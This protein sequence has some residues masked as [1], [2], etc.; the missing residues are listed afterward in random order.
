M[1]QG[2]QNSFDGRGV[3]MV[4][5]LTKFKWLPL[6]LQILLR[7]TI[8]FN[9]WTKCPATIIPISILSHTYAEIFWSKGVRSNFVS[10]LWKS[11]SRLFVSIK[12][13]VLMLIY[14]AD[15]CE[16]SSFFKFQ[17]YRLSFLDG[18]LWKFAA[19]KHLVQ[20][21]KS[22]VRYECAIALVLCALI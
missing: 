12:W 19:R 11:F 6:V 17:G 7:C 2:S 13:R 21:A 20:K 9:W 14:S 5:I 16:Y 3:Q 15:N 18:I 22:N 8:F 1:Y 10:S 4:W